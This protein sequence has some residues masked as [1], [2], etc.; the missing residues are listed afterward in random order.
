LNCVR[1]KNLISN[2]EELVIGSIRDFTGMR[3]SVGK[4]IYE[5]M[6]YLVWGERARI[7]KEIIFGLER[8]HNLYQ[9]MAMSYGYNSGQI[10]YYHRYYI[11]FLFAR[12]KPRNLFVDFSELSFRQ[13]FRLSE[14]Q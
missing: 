6:F 8:D 12:R 2:I 13:F 14:K 7:N 1:Y 9:T 11:P 10:D 3:T 4:A 5:T